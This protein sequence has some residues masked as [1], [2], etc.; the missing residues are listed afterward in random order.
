MEFRE[1]ANVDELYDAMGGL[2]LDLIAALI[3]VGF[4]RW[5]EAGFRLCR[6]EKDWA[7]FSGKSFKITRDG[8]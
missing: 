8:R 6:T 5:T 1:S 3:G 2:G 4:A 7:V